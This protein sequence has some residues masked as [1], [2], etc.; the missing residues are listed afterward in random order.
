MK[1]IWAALALFAVV[2]VPAVAQITGTLGKSTA[3]FYDRYGSPIR[4]RE[5]SE[6]SFITPEVQGAKA[7]SGPFSI[8]TYRAD[9]LTI[10]VHYL[11]PKLEAVCVRYSMP[12]S[13]TRE[14]VNAA[15]KAYGDKWTMIP[16]NVNIFPLYTADNGTSAYHMT[17]ML[18]VQS[19]GL[20]AAFKSSAAAAEAERREVPKF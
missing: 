19:A 18:F 13:W 20:R 9:K 8:R 17:S 14:Q 5:V 4:T 11:L 6:A 7:I 10:E 2:T 16:Q 3:Y 15:L 1:T 12:H